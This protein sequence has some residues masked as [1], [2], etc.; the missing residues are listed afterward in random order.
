MPEVDYE[1][2]RCDGPSHAT[3]TGCVI[4][5]SGSR[6]RSR[7]PAGGGTTPHPCGSRRRGASNR[8]KPAPSSPAGPGGAVDA[9]DTPG[10]GAPLGPP[11]RG[12]RPR[13]NAGDLDQ[14]DDVTGVSQTFQT[15]AMGVANE[16]DGAGRAGGVGAQERD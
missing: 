9:V 8:P 10:R 5:P 13:C 4:G 14:P 11:T 1:P 15:T 2:M 12:A 3:Q 16:H 7:S 6:R